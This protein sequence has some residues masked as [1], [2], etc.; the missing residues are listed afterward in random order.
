MSYKRVAFSEDWWEE[1]EGYL[2]ANPE[3]GFSKEE[4]KQFVKMVVNKH[5][6]Q[7]EKQQLEELKKLVEDLGPN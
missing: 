4:A 3:E 7:D 1:V 2:E 5:M 6:N